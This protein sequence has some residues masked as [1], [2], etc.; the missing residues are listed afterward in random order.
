MMAEV[1]ARLAE[2]GVLIE[3]TE[4]ARDWLA[5]EGFDPVYGA[6][7]LR[8]AIQRHLENDLSRKILSG[9]ISDGDLVTVDAGDDGL[10]FDA[11]PSPA[12]AAEEPDE[13]P[14]RETEQVAGPA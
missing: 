10:S 11:K 14:V 5:G 6:R 3:L 2:H 1:S 4:A 13:S 8:R 7:P 9:D 12:G